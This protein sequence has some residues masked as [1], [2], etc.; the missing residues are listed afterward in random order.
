MGGWL[1]VIDPPQVRE[2]V[3]E[4]AAAVVKRHVRGG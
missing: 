1:E 2:R 4:L 3:V